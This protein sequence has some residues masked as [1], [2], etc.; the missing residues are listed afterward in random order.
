MGDWFRL[1]NSLD[2]RDRDDIVKRQFGEKQNYALIFALACIPFKGGLIVSTFI[3]DVSALRSSFKDACLWGHGVPDRG[4]A[5]WSIL[6][7]TNKLL[8]C[9][10]RC[11]I[12]FQNRY[13][14][15]KRIATLS[16]LTESVRSWDF[17]N[18]EWNVLR[19]VRPL[20]TKVVDATK[21]SIQRVR[22]P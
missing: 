9:S 16:P 19:S 17:C 1:Q 6:W 12:C 14:W 2:L 5:L 18:R 22:S 7:R 10:T 3:I 4:V 20:S 21:P 15:L 8:T 11:G 13:C